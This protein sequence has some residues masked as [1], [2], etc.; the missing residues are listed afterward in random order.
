MP[1]FEGV[2]VFNLRPPAENH[3]GYIYSATLRVKDE[4]IYWAD[5]ELNEEGFAED[6]NGHLN[7]CGSYI[8]A[9]NLKWRKAD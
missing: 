6:E 7:Y 9:L 2:L 4:C 1:S 5:G 3:T 8:K